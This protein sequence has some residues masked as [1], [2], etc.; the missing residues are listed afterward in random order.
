MKKP[1]TKAEREH[2]NA[3][4]ELGCAICKRP[5]QVHHVANQGVRASHYETIPICGYHHTD[6]PHGEAIHQGR[7]TWEARF[8]TERELLVKTLQQLK[9]S[10]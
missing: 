2:M 5:A 4:A 6:G 3:V 7:R 1:A 10:V 9:K 8:G